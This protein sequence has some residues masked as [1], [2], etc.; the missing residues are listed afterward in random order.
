MRSNRMIAMT[1]LALVGLSLG[2]VCMA[3]SAADPKVSPSFVHGETLAHIVPILG[4]EA[5]RSVTVQVG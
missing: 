1:S 5:G 4:R 3:S 2:A